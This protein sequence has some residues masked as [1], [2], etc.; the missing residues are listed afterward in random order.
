MLFIEET[1]WAKK[2]LET[3]FDN[4]E[5][6]SAL[7]GEIYISIDRVIENAKK[8]NVSFEDELSRV[9]I[10]G[11]LHLLGYKDKKTTEKALMREKEEACLSLRK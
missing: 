1:L 5:E 10:H 8:Y 11:V 9:M 7:E 6:A 3:N 2:Q 4:S